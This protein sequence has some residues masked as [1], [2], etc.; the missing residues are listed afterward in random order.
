MPSISA[1]PG[2]ASDGD[3]AGD[4]NLKAQKR[5][6]SWIHRH[7]FVT[8][9]LVIAVGWLFF[10]L[11]IDRPETA[12]THDADAP[13]TSDVTGDEAL[14]DTTP[15]TIPP[16]D[17][18]SHEPLGFPDQPRLVA[19][20]FAQDFTNPA[21]GWWDRV[22]QWTTPALAEAYR[23]TNTA[24][25]SAAKLEQVTEQ[26]TGTSVVDFIADYDNGMSVGIR[27]EYAERE[28]RVTSCVPMKTA[29]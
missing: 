13:A 27:V 28:W 9:G 18:H 26:A 3:D 8:F 5:E 10:T 22:T 14:P 4:H 12:D 1:N 21:P 11:V 19:R 24:R 16:A 7:P 20:S 25:I 29:Y 2:S 15:T 6:P 23:T 17:T